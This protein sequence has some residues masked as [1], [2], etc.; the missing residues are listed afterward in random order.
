[1]TDHDLFTLGQRSCSVLVVASYQW[2]I[3]EWSSHL[4]SAVNFHPSPLPKGRGP[5]HL[6]RAILES[7]SNW[8][9]TYHRINEKFDH[10]DILDAENFQVAPDERHETLRLK[11]QMA[12]ARLATRVATNFTTLNQVARTQSSGSYWVLW[13]E[14]DRTIDFTQPV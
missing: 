6:V 13:T 4:K 12:A 5:Y 2:K 10:G 9:V 7:R 14:Q 11:T 3:P 1:V 8:A